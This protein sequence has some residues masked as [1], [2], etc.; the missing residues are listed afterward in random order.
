MNHNIDEYTYTPDKITLEPR[1]FIGS[2]AS[3][4]AIYRRQGYRL[5]ITV[6]GSRNDEPHE[7][8]ITQSDTT[9]DHPQ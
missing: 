1:S 4:L 5:R 7:R 3:A 6:D 2:L 8:L 9:G